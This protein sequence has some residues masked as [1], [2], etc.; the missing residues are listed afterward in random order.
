MTEQ[1]TD[2]YL[3]WLMS[4]DEEEY[5]I[6]LGKILVELIAMGKAY[7]KMAKLR[8]EMKANDEGYQRTN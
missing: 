2:H 1:P 5:N 8:E 6:E 3:E 4:L 7:E